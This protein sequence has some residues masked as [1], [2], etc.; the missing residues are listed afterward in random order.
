ML[1]KI[2]KKWT[3]NFS[4]NTNIRMKR[5]YEHKKQYIYINTKYVQS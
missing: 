5:N 3:D 4:K 2:R 1:I